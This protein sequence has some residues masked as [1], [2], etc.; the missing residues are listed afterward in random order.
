MKQQKKIHR[1]YLEIDFDK[2]SHSCSSHIAHRIIN[3]LRIK[4]KEDLIIFNHK[5]EQVM[6]SVKLN[7]REVFIVFKEKLENII[8]PK[9]KVH[10]AVS[11]ISMKNM[12]LIVQKIAE[13]GATEFT[14]LY[15]KRS[16]YK[17]VGD[18][19][20]HWRKISIHASEQCSRV[21]I[22]KINTPTS[23]GDYLTKNTSRNKYLLYQNGTSF[24]SEDFRNRDMTI[25][26]GPE[27]GFEDE[28]VELFE[29]YNWKMIN[30]SQNI[31]RTETACISALSIISNYE[32]TSR[33]NI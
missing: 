24:T 4:D 10:I 3:V 8:L 33:H 1:V 14:P 26:V 27:G 20:T 21:D 22:M 29:N 23:L 7:N 17:N 12:D 16:Q 32:S 28:E 31:L 5:R 19:I 18:K 15:T 2:V 25:L 6:A 30:I 9:I 11:T 13:L